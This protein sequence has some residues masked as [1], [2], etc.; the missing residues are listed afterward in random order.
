LITTSGKKSQAKNPTFFIFFVEDGKKEPA[1]GFPFCLRSGDSTAVEDKDELNPT[2]AES[3]FKPVN[4]ML[5]LVISQS[6]A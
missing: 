4:R 2:D 1:G 3:Q 5:S 6:D